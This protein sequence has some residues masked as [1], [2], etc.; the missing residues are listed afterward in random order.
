MLAHDSEAIHQRVVLWDVREAG[1]L[2]GLPS[3]FG[4]VGWNTIHPIS[5]SFEA[6]L[7]IS[8]EVSRGCPTRC[9]SIGD[10]RR[11]PMTFSACSVYR[12]RRRIRP[13]FQARLRRCTSEHRS[14]I[15]A[16]SSEGTTPPFQKFAFPTRPVGAP[17]SWVAFLIGAEASLLNSL[18][19]SRDTGPL[20]P[21]N[22][23]ED[24][25]IAKV[26]SVVGTVEVDLVTIQASRALKGSKKG[27]SGRN[28]DIE[29][30]IMN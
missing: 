27:S 4:A 6:G 20:A 2:R 22:R 30:H 10:V 18:Q 25:A 26:S 8:T 19:A 14:L 15:C 28:H 12:R 9:S 21:L 29:I 11:R 1:H 5:Q 13:V 24:R 16:C 23:K 17:P 7:F 3:T